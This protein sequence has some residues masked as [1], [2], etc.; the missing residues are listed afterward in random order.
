[1][2]GRELI[3]AWS[4]IDRGVAAFVL[5]LDEF[6]ASG[7]WKE[8]GF[9]SCV[10][11]LV[12]QCDLARSTAH[13]K[14][15]VSREL[16]RR[17]AVRAAFEDGL[18]YT[19]VRVL[20][21][22]KSI[23]HERDEEFV[24]HA[25]SDTVRVLNE[26]VENWNYYH[27][28]DDKPMDLDDHYGIRR[29]RGVC[30]GMGKAVIEAPDDFLD[31]LFAVMDAYGQFLFY[32]DKPE[33]LGMAHVEVSAQQTPKFAY[34]DDH[35]SAQQTPDGVSAQQT[36]AY[37]DEPVE[38]RARPRS[39]RRLDWLFDLLEEIA[40]ADP[41]KIDPYTASVGVTINYE[42]LIHKTGNGLSAQGST[43]TGEAVRRLCCDAGIHRVVVKGQSEILDFGREE[44]LFNR[45]MRRAIRFRHGHSCGVRGCGRRI[46][47][48]HHINHFE[49][50]GE[51]EIHNGLPLC[52]YHHHLVHEGGWNVEWDPAT[53]VVTLEGPR[54]QTLRTTA[55][56]LR[57][58]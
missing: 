42:D 51:T 9:A 48:I 30:G 4:Q 24:T 49:H 16:T 14:L 3:A 26:R 37:G 25:G 8:D 7:L 1:V 17:P 29:Q 55:S 10:S 40:L 56:F 39:A 5:R 33:Q 32:N 35:V 6:N 50:G 11:W 21:R 22:L 44:R 13:E 2:Q 45:A 52:D 20:V 57:A 19:K 15:K 28:Q 54:G 53:G 18:P 12:T 34:D 23:D 27:G 43:L 41:K 58:A 46:T 36:P 38:L 47:K 31:R